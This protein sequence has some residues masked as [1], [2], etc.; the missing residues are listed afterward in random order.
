MGV[1]VFVAVG[2]FVGV[3]VSVGVLVGIVGVFVGVFVAVGVSVAVAVAVG[4]S[5]GIVVC[6]LDRL[7][8]PAVTATSPP[9][10]SDHARTRTTRRRVAAVREVLGTGSTGTSFMRNLLARRQRCTVGGDG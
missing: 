8:L 1:G 7:P 5:V 10:H 9:P 3:G 4:V 2:V 6:A